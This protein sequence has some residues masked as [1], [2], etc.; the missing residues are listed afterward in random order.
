MIDII[1]LSDVSDVGY[2]LVYKAVGYGL[3]D[4]GKAWV[5]ISD[6]EMR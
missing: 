6:Q 1:D 5:R 2:G 3:V 4:K